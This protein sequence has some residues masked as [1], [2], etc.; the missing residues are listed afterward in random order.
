MKNKKRSHEA[1]DM[2]IKNVILADDTNLRIFIS[3]E[4]YELMRLDCIRRFD[5]IGIFVEVK[6]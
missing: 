4:R 2:G 6:K 3:P 5:K 1:I